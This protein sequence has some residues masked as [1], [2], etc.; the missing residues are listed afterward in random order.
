MNGLRPYVNLLAKNFLSGAFLLS[1]LL[2]CGKKGPL[3]PPDTV[4]PTLPTPPTL[5][6]NS[7][8]KTQEKAT[9][10]IHK[11]SYVS[12]PPK[13]LENLRSFSANGTIY[14]LWSLPVDKSRLGR[15]RVCRLEK[16]GSKICRIVFQPSFY[17][18]DV[19][20]GV[21]YKY[22]VTVLDNSPKPLESLPA[23]IEIRVGNE[24]TPSAFPSSD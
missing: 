18:Q 20:P 23:E 6:I 4:R 16:D 11:R 24:L 22:R 15:Y 14:L 5:S 13:S 8:E 9:L 21:L 12:T 7:K 3:E 19:K 10:T 1:C 17:D 2:S